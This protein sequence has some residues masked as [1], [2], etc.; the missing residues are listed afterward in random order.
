M[1]QFIS[2]FFIVALVGSAQAQDQKYKTSGDS[3]AAAQ[4]T[5]PHAMNT[6]QASMAQSLLPKTP[7][8]TSWELLQ[9]AE[10]MNLNASGPRKS[11]IGEP[12]KGGVFGVAAE[13]DTPAK[14]EVV[15]SQ[16]VKKLDGKPIKVAGFMM[17]I[18][19]RETHKRFMLSA[20]PPGCPFC[21]PGGPNSIIEVHC[22]TPMKY[23]TDAIVMNGTMSLLKDDP[24]GFYYRMT[25]ATETK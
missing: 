4:N 6:D 20:V 13:D 19:Q 7:G 1:R 25:E 18:E 21:L 8:L 14:F 24:S 10:L 17:P 2:L 16:D 9:Q 5:T 15:F 22:K 23:T 12:G 11:H 3:K